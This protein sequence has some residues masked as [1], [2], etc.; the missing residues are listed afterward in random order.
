M[1]E[2]RAPATC[3]TETGCACVSHL[4]TPADRVASLRQLLAAEPEPVVAVTHLLRLCRDE[5]PTLW[6]HH[7][8][9]RCRTRVRDLIAPVALALPDAG[10]AAS[11]PP[12]A[13]ERLAAA[14]TADRNIPPVVF[15]HALAELIDARTG[16]ASSAGS[17]NA[18]RTAPLRATRSLSAT[19]TLAALR[20]SR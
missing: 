7:A 2:A 13:R 20:I 17:A 6:E 3:R 15:A 8:D 16:T 11:I 1:N 12:A 9:A 19:L 14:L 18:A 5:H 4:G 10:V